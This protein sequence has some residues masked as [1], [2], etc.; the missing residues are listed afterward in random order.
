LASF[1]AV[2]RSLRRPSINFRVERE[3]NTLR[4]RK[5]NSIRKKKKIKNKEINSLPRPRTPFAWPCVVVVAVVAAAVVH[6]VL[7]KAL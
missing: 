5:K 2:S 4:E 6:L 7:K 3:N 1:G